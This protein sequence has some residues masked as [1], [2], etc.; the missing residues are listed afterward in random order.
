MELFSSVAAGAPGAVGAL[1]EQ[2]FQAALCARRISPPQRPGLPK[3][4][5]HRLGIHGAGRGQDHVENTIVEN[6]ILDNALGEEP[7]LPNAMV[8]ICWRARQTIGGDVPW[9]YRHADYAG[10]P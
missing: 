4:V 8:I 5:I 10:R 9:H 2:I 1:I 7:Q 6:G 3:S